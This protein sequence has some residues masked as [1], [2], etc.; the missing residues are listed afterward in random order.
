MHLTVYPSWSSFTEYCILCRY[1]HY[2]VVILIYAQYALYGQNITHSGKWECVGFCS[3]GT[4][5]IVIIQPNQTAVCLLSDF[6]LKF[7]YNQSHLWSVTTPVTTAVKD[8]TLSQL[9]GFKHGAEVVG[10][11]SSLPPFPS[12]VFPY[13]FFF[14]EKD[15]FWGKVFLAVDK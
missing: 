5:L 7:P 15:N 6:L 3:S 4:D 9:H 8:L 11:F 2:P 1:L 12:L 10:F 13:Y 14:H